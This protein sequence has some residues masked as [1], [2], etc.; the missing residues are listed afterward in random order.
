LPGIHLLFD[1]FLVDISETSRQEHASIG[2][3]SLRS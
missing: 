1:A 3:M 2:T